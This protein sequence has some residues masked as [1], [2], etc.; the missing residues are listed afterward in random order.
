MHSRLHENK[1]SDI[2]CLGKR[3]RTFKTQALLVSS[4]ICGN[5]LVAEY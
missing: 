2:Y 3:S 5:L 4:D 1:G